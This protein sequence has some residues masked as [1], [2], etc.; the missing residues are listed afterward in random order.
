MILQ[1]DYNLSAWFFSL[2]RSLPEGL[3]IFLG[4]WLIF[5]L[6]GYVG[7]VIFFAW[8]RRQWLIIFRIILA[9]IGS[10][11]INLIIA[12]FYF[13][14]RPYAALGFS[15]VLTP[16]LLEQSFP[17][18]HAAVA[19]ALAGSSWLHNKKSGLW[20]LVAAILISLG[21]VLAGV[22]YFGDILFGGLIGLAVAW[23]VA[24]ISFKIRPIGREQ[25]Q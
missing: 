14:A 1:L 17:S 11:I 7:A 23:F 18:S 16:L 21:R 12:Y 19:W 15:P 24:Q 25:K 9:A 10:F 8:R 2:G 5:F 4:T 22:H 3:V 13:R 6:Y 20:A